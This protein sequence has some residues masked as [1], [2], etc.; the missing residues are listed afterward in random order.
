MNLMQQLKKGS[1][2]LMVLSVLQE[3][4]MYGYQ[5]MRELEERSQGYFSMTAASLYPTLHKLEEE[6]L[7]ISN[8]QEGNGKRRRKYYTIT[9][10]GEETLGDHAQE[11]QTFAKQ[12]LALI[13]PNLRQA[14]G[15]A[16]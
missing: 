1:T 3:Q 14:T 4:P 11:W 16:A 7:V 10:K 15:G 6:N 8:W 2:P 13:P 5:I 9:Q 12:L